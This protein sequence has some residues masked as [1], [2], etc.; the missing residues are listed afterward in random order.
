MATLNGSYLNNLT[1]DRESDTAYYCGDATIYAVPLA[2]GE[3]R[4]SAYLPVNAWSGSDTT[5]GALSGG[6]IVYAN[7]DGAYVRRLDTPELA[8]AR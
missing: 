5:F 4:V 7:G 6:M 2:T 8:A 1:Y 3:S